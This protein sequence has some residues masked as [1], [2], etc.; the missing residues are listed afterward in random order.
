[1][2]HFKLTCGNEIV[3]LV[4][5]T[6][7]FKGALFDRFA[8]TGS[9]FFAILCFFCLCLILFH[10]SIYLLDTL[11]YSL[12]VIFLSQ[13]S[14]TLSL[15]LSPPFH[16]SHLIFPLAKLQ[17]PGWWSVQVTVATTG[18]FLSSCQS[19][20]IGILSWAQVQWADENRMCSPAPHNNLLKKM[21]ANGNTETNHMPEQQNTTIKSRETSHLLKMS[22]SQS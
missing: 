6:V 1:M 21:P 10:F 11:P 14:T 9:I 22:F 20:L 5:S 4:C 16:F 18:P 7:S 15:P 13:P 8:A 2:E 12:F 3:R 17:R 19:E